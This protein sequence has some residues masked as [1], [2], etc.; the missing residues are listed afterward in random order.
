VGL[1]ASLEADQLEDGVELETLLCGA[2]GDHERSRR[3]LPDNDPVVGSREQPGG[4]ARWYR[5]VRQSGRHYNMLL[6]RRSFQIADFRLLSSA[7]RI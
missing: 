5:P 1:E 2:A 7:M 4:R 3:R 6:S